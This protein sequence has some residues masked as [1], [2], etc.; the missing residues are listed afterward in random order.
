MIRIAKCAIL[1]L[2]INLWLLGSV[3]A[4]AADPPK[5]SSPQIE[6]VP[7]EMIVKFKARVRPQALGTDDQGR[8]ATDLP[9]LNVLSAR[10]RVT[11]MDM[12][13]KALPVEPKARA[14]LMQKGLNRIYKLKVDEKADLAQVIRAFKSSPYVEYAEPNYIAH[15]FRIPNDLYWS[16]Q[17][18]MT[19]IEAPAAWD[20]TTGSDSVTIAI[21]D[22]GV[23]L[24]HPD[25]DDKLVSGYDF[26]NGDDDPQDDYGHGTHVAGI[27]AAKTNN[28]TGV[29][30]L[31]WGAK[32][33]PVKV[34]ND[35]G[36]GGYE[37]V[38]N[39]IIYAANNGADIINLSLG[40]SASSSVLEEAVEYAHDLGCVIVAATGNNNS[41]VSYP[42]R[43]PRVIAVAATDSNDQR[44]SFSNYGPE[45]DVTAPGVSIRSTYWWAGS[46]YE[47]VSG[48]SQASPHVAG[49]AALIWSLSPGLDNT[50]V[51]SIIKQ[52]ADD[53]GVAG[54]DNYCGFGRI[55]A[56]RAL[57]ATAPSLAISRSMSFLADPVTDPSSQT[58]PIG[59]GAMYGTLQWS[60][61]EN[62]DVTWLSIGPP[63]SGNAS[64]PSSGELTV[65]VDRD[66]AGQGTHSAAILV[67]SSNP[68]I[69][70]SPWDVNVTLA[71]A[72]S[73]ERT[74]LPLVTMSSGSW[75][76]IAADGTILSLGDDDVQKLTLP[77]DFRFY[78]TTYDELW[79]SSNG[80]VSFANGY[81]NWINDCLPDTS[82]PNNA[83]Y[84]LWD[85]LR[86]ADGG[87]SGTIYAKQVDSE[88]FVVEWYKVS[89]YTNSARETF[90]I[91][92]KKDNTVLLQYQSL[93]SASSAT[94]G[95]ENINSTV[96]Q[97]YWC[98]GSGNPLYNGLVVEF[99]TP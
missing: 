36:S 59:N 98:N 31:S 21:V 85:D 90:E 84:A 61:V 15:V 17:W 50:Q 63:T 22:T 94:V 58:L 29:A 72:S 37:D 26:I 77:F 6:F 60:A 65:S 47:R 97:Q 33:M 46:T 35:Y 40:G 53:L 91:V 56:R 23:D 11:D 19:K 51:E 8:L 30:G 73:L 39:G 89:H 20:I 76:D 49:L 32:I 28:G 69:Q 1:V 64:L 44:A 62:P 87:G 24:L 43:H 68:Y 27:A 96:T 74:Y 25:L 67:I 83:I 70:N 2:L 80:F 41:S 45:V 79:V 78:G 16:S 92:L 34:L 9:F 66:V 7:G 57:E 12:M 86:P 5:P 55:N 93:S 81:T 54:R 88:T 82:A 14:T 10:H 18:G 38:A 42:A 75:I 48:T 95:V 52:T 3:I 71:Y 99:T 4:H 13:V